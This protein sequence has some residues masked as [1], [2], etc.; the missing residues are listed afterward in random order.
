MDTVDHN[1]TFE[2]PCGESQEVAKQHGFRMPVVERIKV[3]VLL[4][5]YLNLSYLETEE[6]TTEHVQS[7]AE[8]SRTATK[9]A[10]IKSEE[11]DCSSQGDAHRIG[12][13]GH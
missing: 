9:P 4:D 3:E 7:F 8:S 5:E 6:N 13:C 10:S 1:T 2:Q 11:G 12:R